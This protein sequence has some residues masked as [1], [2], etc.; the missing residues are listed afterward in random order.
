[1]IKKIKNILVVSYLLILIFAQPIRALGSL[2]FA[3]RS[4]SIILDRSINSVFKVS[5]ASSI[6]GWNQDSIITDSGS[7]HPGGIESG[8]IYG[9]GTS[10]TATPSETLVVNNSNAI[11]SLD[12]KVR[13]NSNAINYLDLD[14]KTNTN[15]FEF[16]LASRSK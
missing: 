10:A 2:T 3:N 1:M 12:T 9:Y 14:A 16:V 4:A 7:L 13:T 6:F 11:V 8:K 15:A 5:K